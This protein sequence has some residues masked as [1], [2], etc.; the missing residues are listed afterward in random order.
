MSAETIH[1]CYADAL[2]TLPESGGGGCHVALLGVANLGALAKL[3][4][5]EVS[6][7]L[8]ANIHGKRRVLDREIRQAV[9]KAFCDCGKGNGVQVTGWRAPRHVPRPALN[10][11]KMLRGVLSRG[12]GVSDVDLWEMSPVRPD[13]QPERDA[14]ELLRLL[15]SPEDQLFIGTKYDTGAE[16]VHTVADWRKRFDTGKP[17]PEHV[18]PNPLTG[19]QGKT[20]EGKPSFRADSC[21]Q[22]FRFGVLEFDTVPEP[23]RDPGQSAEAWPRESQCHFWAGALTFNWPIAVLIDSGGKSIHAWLTVNARD[24]ADWTAT[25]EGELFARFLVPC[26]VDP[27][28][29]NE[30]RLSRMPGH[31]RAATK[32]WQKIIYLNP[33]AGQEGR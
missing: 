3:T 26:G 7:D 32:R 14:A 9:A 23:L 19:E 28:C 6:Q 5:D 18:I 8:R 31:F 29:R 17:V 22:K 15:Y 16:H 1:R 24:V 25:I 20:K 2:R 10:P 21:V 30:A 27:S 13:W 12:D 11:V 4:P 33:N